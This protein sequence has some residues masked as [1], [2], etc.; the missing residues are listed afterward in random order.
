MPISRI[1]KTLQK[2]KA[3]NVGESPAV[4]LTAVMEYLA[5]EIWDLAGNIAYVKKAPM[6]IAFR[7][8]QRLNWKP[9]NTLAADWDKMSV[10]EKKKAW[11]V[12]PNKAAWVANKKNDLGKAS[13]KSHI[14]LPNHIM[15]AIRND[16]ELKKVFGGIIPNGGVVPNIH[17]VLLPKKS[18]SKKQKTA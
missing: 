3:V 7:T 6:Q 8:A 10:D 15:L 4:Y 17:A 2:G 12:F 16:E 18:K 14:I 1:R 5:A 11:K 9:D 13:T